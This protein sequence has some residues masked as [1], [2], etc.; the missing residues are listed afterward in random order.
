MILNDIRTGN[1][2]LTTETLG[3]PLIFI[4]KEDNCECPVGYMELE[5]PV[6]VVPGDGRSDRSWCPPSVP[7]LTATF[8][9]PPSPLT[10]LPQA[11][12]RP[13]TQ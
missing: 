12:G 10:S 13:T 11:L 7:R 5:C 8:V 4:Y 2:Y 3:Y 1:C 6:A 9:R